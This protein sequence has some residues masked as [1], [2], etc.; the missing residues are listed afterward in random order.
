MTTNRKLSILIVVIAVAIGAAYLLGTKKNTP[1]VSSQIKDQMPDFEVYTN[2]TVNWKT[3]ADRKFG[4]SFQYPPNSNVDIATVAQT[5]NFSATI[6]LDCTGK[7]SINLFTINTGNYS[8]I[9]EFKKGNTSFSPNT[10]FKETVFNGEKTVQHYYPGSSQTGA[11]VTTF[12]MHNGIGYQIIYRL[13]ALPGTALTD[14]DFS[15]IYPDILSTITFLDKE[16]VK[17]GHTENYEKAVKIVQAIPE[18]TIIENAVINKGKKMRFSSAGGEFR[19]IVTVLLF[20]EG[21]PDLHTSR[22]DTFMVNIKTNDIQVY[23]ASTIPNKN[24]SLEEWKK[25]VKER[26]Q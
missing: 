15:I 17:N 18:M 1:L 20:E 7:T 23:S 25:T 16:N 3:Y 5:K 19:D 6:T 12:L 10:P 4:I 26:F 13:C 24:I 14:S 8:S 22:I 21:F 2:K 9:E 11:Q